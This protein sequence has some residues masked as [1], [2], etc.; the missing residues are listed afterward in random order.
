M[1]VASN[2]FL[3]VAAVAL[4]WTVMVAS[5]SAEVEVFSEPGG[6]PCTEVTMVGH[7]VAGGC[8]IEIASNQPKAFI[9]YVPSPV[10][11]SSCD[12]HLE[13][14]IGGAGTGLVSQ[15]A[16]SPPSPPNGS[17]CTR[18]PCDEANGT[19]L[20]WPISISESAGVE[21]G[22]LA[23][24][25]RPIPSGPGASGTHC[26]LHLPVTDLGSHEYEIGQSGVEICEEIP[27]AG[28]QGFGFTYEAG[29]ERLEI[30][31]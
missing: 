29:S 22:E 7:Q 14:R 10:V 5:A 6:E 17:S 21:T 24:C 3:T 28:L 19:M 20:P 26:T 9:A 16:F 23:F 25:L 27:N 8:H 2:S 30:I 31:H 12:L 18:V 1:R 11:L 13:A 4:A 15:A